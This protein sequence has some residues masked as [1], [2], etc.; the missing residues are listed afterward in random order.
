MG[1]VLASRLERARERGIALPE[2][3]FRAAVAVYP[4]GCR[5]GRNDVLGRP[6]LILIGGDDDWTLPGPCL[7]LVDGLRGRGG[8]ADIV[9]YPGAYHYFDLEGQAKA[10]VAEVGNDNRPGGAGAT[11]AF[12]AAAAADARRRVAEFFARHLGGR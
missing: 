12:D 6:L 7:E 4:G 8:E 11:V 3:G 9:V 5:A 1:V 2:V 10:F